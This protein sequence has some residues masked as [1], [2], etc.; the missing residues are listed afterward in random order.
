M[1]ISSDF[2]Y[3]V[4]NEKPVS[5]STSGTSRLIIEHNT[6]PPRP[7]YTERNAAGMKEM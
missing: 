4:V 5:N 2:L 6:L 3:Q 7:I 1:S